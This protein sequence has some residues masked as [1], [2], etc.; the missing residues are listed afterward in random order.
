MYGYGLFEQPVDR[1]PEAGRG[2]PRWVQVALLTPLVAVSVW[3]T[4]ELVGL[5][6]P[7]L[8][9]SAVGSVAVGG[10][11]VLLI[12]LWHLARK[13]R[14]PSQQEANGGAAGRGTNETL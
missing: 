9:W 8:T 11:S 10:G 13:W 4:G 3:L 2:A 12:C 7:V 1:A 14:T 6:H 5:S